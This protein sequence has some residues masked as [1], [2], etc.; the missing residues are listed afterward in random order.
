MS[1]LG[2]ALATVRQAALPAGSP[3]PRYSLTTDD[4]TWMRL[5]DFRGQRSVVL[6]FCRGLDD[7]TAGWLRG[8]ETELAR[9]EGLEALVV[10]THH[11]PAPK[12]RA[13]KEAHGLSL[14]IS[15]D[16][17]AVEARAWHFASRLLPVGRAGAAIVSKEGTV[18]LH[19][20][21]HVDPAALLAQ[22][23]EL[24]GVEASASSAA[25]AAAGPPPVQHVGS[26]RA[27]ALLSGDPGFKLV[28]VRTL[29]EFEADHA[30]MAVH[31]PVDELP[32]R[33]TEL[34]QIE[35]LLFV[36]QAGG[37]STA[38]AEFLASIG[39]TDIYN[40]VGGMSAWSGPRVTGGDAQ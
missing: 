39:G 11:A 5:R 1:R 16:P 14:P 36:C 25:A 15:Y 40:V 35:K 17:F 9:F 2:H 19:S 22:V 3:A 20:R 6:L 8:I 10:A 21:G 7:E 27:V 32:Q 28:D 37:R 24:E 31:I 4:G 34:G 18:V 12:L 26:T 30:P 38:A 29:S 33:Y 13:F 23:A